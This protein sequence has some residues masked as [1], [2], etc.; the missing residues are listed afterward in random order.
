MLVGYIV[1]GVIFINATG[2]ESVSLIGF[3]T[4][5]LAL[6]H[7]LYQKVENITVHIVLSMFGVRVVDIVV[8]SAQYIEYDAFVN[9]TYT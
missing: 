1:F 4:A 7:F 5:Y 6:W 2:E 3:L 9:G 8:L